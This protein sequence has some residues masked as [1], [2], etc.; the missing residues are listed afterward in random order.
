M[1]EDD[2]AALRH[3]LGR[4][5]RGTILPEEALRLRRAVEGLIQHNDIMKS[6]ILAHLAVCG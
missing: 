2:I 3:L 1:T 6:A 5:E 4:A